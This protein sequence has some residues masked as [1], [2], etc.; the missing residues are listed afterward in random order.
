MLL[1]SSLHSRQ[2]YLPRLGLNEQNN[3]DS[4]YRRR[5]AK[6]KNID[7]GGLHPFEILERDRRR[8]LKDSIMYWYD[9]KFSIDDYIDKV[10][11]CSLI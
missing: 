3:D 5:S 2:H 6:A 1:S 10:I 7:Y 11:K 4:N 9:P 8:G